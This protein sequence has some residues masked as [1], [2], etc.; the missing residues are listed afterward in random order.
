FEEAAAA[1]LV[2]TTAW[3]MLITRAQLRAGET[4]LI[5]GS[6]GGVNSA[7]IQI[8]KLAGA[9]VTVLAGGAQKAERAKALGADDVIDYHATPEWDREVMRRTAKQ[10]VDVIVDNVGEKTWTKSLKAA[11]KGGRIVTVGGTTGYNPQAGINYIMWKQLSIHGSTMGNRREFRTVMGLV[12]DGRLKPV[13]DRVMPL[14][15][16]REAQELLARGEPFGKIVLT[17]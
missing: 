12:F 11:A 4:V 6:G 16:G 14:S 17:P 10:G 5:V 1:G 3:R 13:V 9:R 15:Q 2:Y 8:A 7:A